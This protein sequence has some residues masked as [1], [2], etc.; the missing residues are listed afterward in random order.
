MAVALFQHDRLTTLGTEAMQ[1][2]IDKIVREFPA[3]GLSEH[4]F[5]GQKRGIYEKELQ[6]FVARGQRQHQSAFNGFLKT[7]LLVQ[8]H[9]PMD[10]AEPIDIS[11]DA[12]QIDEELPSPAIVEEILTLAERA[13][14]EP[15]F[16]LPEYVL[17]VLTNKPLMDLIAP[18]Y[19]SEDLLKRYGLSQHPKAA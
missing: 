12:S 2:E 17:T 15:T 1:R 4:S 5:Q 13:K 9:F 6:R 18:H 8:K 7:L 19:D 11:S 16:Q 3:L 14:N 10:P